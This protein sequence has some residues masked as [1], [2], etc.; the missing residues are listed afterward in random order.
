MRKSYLPRSVDQILKENE[1]EVTTLVRGIIQNNKGKILFLKR[2]SDAKSFPNTWNLP[3]GKL[4]IFEE[5]NDEIIVPRG[6]E[7]PSE[8][9]E[10]EI[11]EETGLIVIRYHQVLFG[12][13]LR[14]KPL[15]SFHPSFRGFENLIFLVDEWE[16]NVILNPMESSEF[17][18]FLPGNMPNF[19]Y[20]F[21]SLGIV[22]YLYRLGS[23]TKQLPE[24][25]YE[26]PSD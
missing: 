5:P 10:R 17:G 9:F 13:Q 7:T 15:E 8:A 4:E 1:I 14:N 25:F 26:S 12:Q 2:L 21:E 16:G 19:E 24:R 20:S 22:K 3:G 11:Y 18:W 23:L 6:Y